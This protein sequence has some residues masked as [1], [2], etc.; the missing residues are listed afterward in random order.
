MYRKCEFQAVRVSEATAEP[1]GGFY[2]KRKSYAK[3]SYVQTYSP[4]MF[5]HNPTRHWRQVKVANT[6]LHSRPTLD[7]WQVFQVLKRERLKCM[8]EHSLNE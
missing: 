6:V 1:T 3:E 5:Q 8:A 4:R 2:L 7:C